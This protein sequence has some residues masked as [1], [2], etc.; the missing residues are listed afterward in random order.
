M[1]GTGR[2]P[3]VSLL[4]LIYP[5]VGLISKISNSIINYH[6][7]ALSVQSLSRVR[8]FATPWSLCD[9]MEYT[10]HGILWARILE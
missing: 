6:Q 5:L 4:L 9:P 10:V 7:L 2:Y 8:L 1:T 3:L